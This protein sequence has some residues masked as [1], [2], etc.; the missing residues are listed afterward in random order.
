MRNRLHALCPY[1]AMFPESF[2]ERWI[3]ELTEPNDWVLDPFCG[4]GTAPFQ[5]LLMGRRAVGVDV[6][7]V[8]YCVTRAKTNAPRAGQVRRRLTLLERGFEPHE[9]ELERRRLAPFFRSAFH[10]HALR[11][12]LYLR[13]TLRWRESSVDCMIAALT[14]GSLHGETRSPSYMSNQMPRTISTKPQYSLRFWRDRDLKPPYRDPFTIIRSRLAFRYETIP[15]IGAAEILNADMRELPRME[16]RNHNIR[17]V[18]TSPPY[19]DVTSFEEDQWLRLWFLGG[20]PYPQRNVI[21]RD[22]RHSTREAYWRLIADM[23]RALGQVLAPQA[24]IVIR[25]GAKDILPENVVSAL[26][27]AA[28]FSRRTVELLDSEVSEIP[29]RQTDAFRPGAP[30]CAREVDCHFMMT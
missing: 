16:T 25:I 6:N 21:S 27:G 1:F 19:L 13:H 26:L 8:A 3:D 9:W 20:V 28:V 15:P 2:A 4:R 12:I 29:R 10:P 11:I 18:I 24:H 17:C 7:P 5:A 30:G 23:W 14:L 22:D